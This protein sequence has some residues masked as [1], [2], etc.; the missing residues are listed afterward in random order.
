MNN[1][2]IINFVKKYKTRLLHLEAEEFLGWIVRHIPGM[3]GFI[4]R[5]F[6]YRFLFKKLG[7][8]C[9]IYSGVYLTH[10]YGISI[11][12]GGSITSGAALDG[13][14]GITIGDFVLIGPH[15]Y[16]SS[17]NHS[18]KKIS[19]PI[20]EQGHNMKPVVIKDDVWIGAN[21]TILGGVTIGKGSVIGAGAVVTK[22]VPSYSIMGGVPAR[23]IGS[24]KAH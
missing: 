13:R 4:V 10:T 14:G 8:S 18:F 5:S 2:I 15:V 17:S 3:V 20:A 21:A 6:V 12:S 19:I 16:V 11:G 24:R 1:K 7:S 22:D 9:L 23:K